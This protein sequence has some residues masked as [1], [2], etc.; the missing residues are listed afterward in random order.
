MAL[1]LMGL[2]ARAPLVEPASG[3]PPTDASLVLPLTYILL[4]PICGVYDA[5]TLLSV[6]QHLGMLAFV[7]LVYG[8]ARVVHGRSGRS[9]V[10]LIL[11]ESVRAVLVVVG[12][13]A[14]YAIG[15]FVP[16]PMASLRAQERDLL[17]LDFHSHT[18]RSHDGSPGFT[19]AANRSWH[20]AAGFDVAFV[21]DHEYVDTALA[22]AARNPALAGDGILLLPG[23]EF[24]LDGQHV[25]SLDTRQPGDVSEPPPVLIQTLPE[26]LTR[27]PVPGPGG[28]GGVLGIEVVDAAPRGLAQ[29]DRDRTT[30]L[31]I[32]DSLD[33][34][35]VA[36]SNNHGWGRTAAAW[37]LMRLPGWRRSPSDA[38]A[39]TISEAIRSQRKAAVRA[40]ARRRVPEPATTA[41]FVLTGPRFIVH[42]LTI[43]TW[44]ERMAWGA[45]ILG[46]AF[47]AGILRRPTAGT[48]TLS[49]T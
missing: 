38:L 46:G 25:V 39:S 29:A 1:L 26:D 7:V 34:A 21:T 42:M 18:N 49:R 11:G 8:I 22:A 17:V 28:R 41:G 36:S 13:F 45:W 37:S 6:G 44:P 14:V 16:R 31:E 43:L 35:L 47:L 30:I 12:F 20:R 32:A 4:A 48:I 5:L 24:F 3:T 9:A 2:V 27:V 33:L 15:V 23:L 40:V 19:A 10:R